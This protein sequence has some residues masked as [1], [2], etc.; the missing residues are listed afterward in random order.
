[1]S[2]NRASVG[3]Q[4]IKAPSKRRLKRTSG[5]R[6]GAKPMIRLKDLKLRLKKSKKSRL[7]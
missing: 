7:Y 6:N 3:Q 5:N 1:M 4:I 2:I